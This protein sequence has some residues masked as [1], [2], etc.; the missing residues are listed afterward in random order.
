VH[1]LRE[2]YQDRINFVI[3]D[4]DVREENDLAEELGVRHHPAFGFVS[5]E[6]EVVSRMF[7]PQ[8]EA[9]LVD[10]IEEFI[11]S[12]AGSSDRS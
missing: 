8:Q 5:P 2:Q 3:L 7:G 4:W 6:G 12:A 1:G 10:A 11:S 9:T